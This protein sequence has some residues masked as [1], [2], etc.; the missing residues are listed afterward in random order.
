VG[1][2][3]NLPLERY[4]SLLHLSARRLQLDPRLRRR[5]D[6]SDLV[7]ETL[8]KAHRKRAQFRGESEA[9]FVK[10]LQQILV[11]TCRDEL[12]RAD[13]LKQDM[14]LERSLEAA[15]ADSSACLEKCLAADEPSPSQQA[16]QHELCLRLADALAQ[17][18]QDQ[19]DVVILR[20]LNGNS[21][22]AIAEQLGR[23]EKSVAGLLL[24]GRRRLAEIMRS[25]Q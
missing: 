1:P 22:S 21:V 3:H 7:Q 20:D 11:N 5:L 15:I 17:L 18:P 8:L 12:R 10:W 23:T 13:A 16:Q 14:R 2:P 24:R 25:Y 4:R 9:E 19:Q 6:A